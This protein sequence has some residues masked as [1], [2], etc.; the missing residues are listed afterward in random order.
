MS[1]LDRHFIFGYGSLINS[2]SRAVTGESG[3]V[4]AVRICGYERSWSVMSVDFGMSSVAVV[5][6]EGAYCNG[7]LVEVPESEIP[8]FDR[9]EQGYQR[10]LIERH[11]IE[12]YQEIDLPEGTLWIYH[13]HEIVPPTQACPIALSYAD[14]ILA[15]CI[16]HGHDFAAEFIALTKGWECP[17]LNDRDA[18][19]YPRVQPELSTPVLN[20][21]MASVINLSDDQLLASYD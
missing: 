6:R 12:T 5:Q 14:V 21:L 19:R 15:G 2:L 1:K 10:S 7:V 4:L 17:A 16:E 3:K 18:P 8:H 13:A 20:V 9:R 11:Q